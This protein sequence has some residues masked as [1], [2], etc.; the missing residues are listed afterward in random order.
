MPSMKAIKQRRASVKNMQQ[1]MR[2]MNLVA[3]AKLQRARQEWQH[4]RSYVEG[5][6]NITLS[7]AA[8]KRAAEHFYVQGRPSRN[9]VYL[10][11]SSDRGKCGGY[12][13]NV[14][15]AA[16]AHAS[17]YGKNAKF[18]VVGL[19]GLEFFLSRG[20]T[21]QYEAAP[22]SM[23]DF[24]QA[25]Q[26]GEMLLNLYR[27]TEKANAGD[28]SPFGEVDEVYV[29][30]TKFTSILATEPTVVQVLPL[31]ARVAG[32]GDVKRNAMEYDPSPEGFIDYMVHDYLSAYI[33]GAMMESVVC[34]QAARMLNMDA[35][36]NNAQEIIEDL[37]LMFNRQRQGAITQEITEIVS[38]ANALQ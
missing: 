4:I 38:G 21:A 13:L 1:A 3:T 20:Q 28:E 37:T 19:K 24:S 25:K 14:A 29:V 31:S 35:A 26:L 10:V 33:Y 23:P 2:A 7:A 34:E 17:D 27:D 18:I 5:A 36:T 16:A 11:I 32:Q 15:K 8:D 22:K 30:Y 9:A 12:N 6:D